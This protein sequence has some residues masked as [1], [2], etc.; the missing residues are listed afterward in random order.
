MSKSF[1]FIV[2]GPLA[3]KVSIMTTI[4]SSSI[5]VQWDAMDDSLI[6]TY[7]LTWFSSARDLVSHRTEQTSYTI[8]GLI[9]NTV[10][11]IIAFAMNSCGTGPKFTTSV[12]LSASTTSTTS[13]I[14]PTV[15]PSTSPVTIMSTVYTT[16]INPSTTSIIS[17]NPSANSFNSMI[18]TSIDTVINSVES[19]TTTIN[20]LI[21][22]ISTYT[23]LLSTS[24]AKTTMANNNN[25][26]FSVIVILLQ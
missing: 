14:T 25:S 7:A 12:I 13:S 9:L 5:V 6:T 23:I 8:N 2:T 10:Y 20:N 16:M 3:L 4:E 18:S 22:N 26:E 24:P 1:K 21:S 19:T 17:T 15:T 11:V